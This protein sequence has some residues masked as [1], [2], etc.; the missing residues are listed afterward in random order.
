MKPKPEYSYDLLWDFKSKSLVISINNKIE[1]PRIK[2]FSLKQLSRNNT[3]TNY[4]IDLKKNTAITISEFI[5]RLDPECQ[6]KNDQLVNITWF[7]SSISP[8]LTR[9]IQENLD[10]GQH[11]LLTQALYD[12]HEIIRP[13]KSLSK[14]DY[15]FDI[16]S[17]GYFW[18][19]LSAM[20]G[21]DASRD[22]PEDFS[23]DNI[24]SLHHKWWSFSTHN[25]D[26]EEQYLV[27]LCGIAGLCTL[28][29]NKK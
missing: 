4:A 16:Y 18:I 26:C 28:Y 9:F 5:K 7:C 11:G 25:V 14:D 29:R 22:N 19:Y 6:E 13:G 10:E 27:I 21:V 8:R 1:L 24:G 2:N 12:A 17:K 15:T 3:Y 20:G 23:S